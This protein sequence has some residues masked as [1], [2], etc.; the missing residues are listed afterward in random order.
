MDYLT[1]KIIDS[2]LR[3]LSYLNQRSEFEEFKISFEWNILFG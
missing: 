3:I 2:I 1:S